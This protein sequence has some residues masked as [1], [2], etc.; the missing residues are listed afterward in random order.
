MPSSRRAFLTG[1]GLR[2]P[3]HAPAASSGYFLRLSR[4]AMACTLELLL[5]PGER[6]RLPA[7]QHALERVDAIESQL[8]V[9][10]ETSEVARL[11]RDAASR[12]V[13]VSNSLYRLLRLARD[14]GHETGGAY[15]VT[16]GALVRCWGF[17]R[18]SG[19]IPDGMTLDRARNAS[20]WSR[21]R[22]DDAAETIAFATSGLEINLGSI[23]KGYALDCIAA[24]LRADGVH[25]FLLH[26]GHSSVLAAGDSGA[27]RGWIV[28][29]ADGRS[30]GARLGTIALSNQSLST[31]GIGQ[32]GFAIDGRRYGPIID[33]RSGAPS[34]ACMQSSVVAPSAALS[35]AL[36]TAFFVMQEHEA[37]DYC[38][39][40]PINGRVTLRPAVDAPIVERVDLAPPPTDS[41]PAGA[42]KSRVARLSSS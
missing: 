7:A 13:Q 19:R 17:L 33:P 23:G 15:D 26:A 40:H 35:E 28:A 39:V 38:A 8:T 3:H 10:R 18:R 21:V 9:F 36:S 12:P 34:D 22:F 14:I 5:P 2:S 42:S 20:G 41:V 6:D 24:A 31:S 30:P 1:A 32:Q 16:C 37:R 4:P 11:N 27:T 29:I 25:D